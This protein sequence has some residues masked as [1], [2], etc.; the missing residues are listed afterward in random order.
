MTL[1]YLNLVLEDRVKPG[2]STNTVGQQKYQFQQI[3]VFKGCVR[4]A[5]EEPPGN[6]RPARSGL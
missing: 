4:G 2:I 1:N 6:K 5:L 3:A